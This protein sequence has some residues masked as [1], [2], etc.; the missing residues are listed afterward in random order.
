MARRRSPEPAAR[1]RA[2]AAGNF[3][4]TNIAQYMTAKP[5]ATATTASIAAFT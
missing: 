4:R 5:T 3:G 1:C 2:D